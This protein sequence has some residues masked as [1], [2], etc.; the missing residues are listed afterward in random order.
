MR[1]I[2][3][4]GNNSGRNAGDNAILGNLLDDFTLSRQDIH[5]KI[6]S[7]NPGFIN[8]YF[9]HHSVEPMGM[10]PWNLALKNLGLPLY[11][12]MTRTEMVLITD[13]ILFDR[14]FNNPFVNYLKSIALF[15]DSC[16]KRKIPIV[17]YNAS[18]GPI[19]HAVGREALQ[20][21]MDASKLVIARDNNTKDL[22]QN[23]NLS[24]PEIIVHADCAL[25]TSIPSADHMDRI[26]KKEDLFKGANGTIGFN[27]NAYVDNWSKPGL[28]NRKDFVQII[29]GTIDN[30]ID[31]L[32]I[33]ILFTV[34][35]VMDLKITDECVQQVRNKDKVRVV[36]N[37]DY[38]YQELAGLLQ[39][40]DIHAGLRTHTL[41]FCAAVNTPMVNINA[42]P[43]SAGFMQTIGQGD[44]TLNFED[45][46]VDNLSAIMLKAW[47][48][49]GRTR[50]E[51]LPL[52]HTEKSKARDSVRLVTE[53]L[54]KL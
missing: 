5:F 15:S 51:M 41:I 22:I 54:D 1:T 38:T 25:N 36:N 35:Q 32:D 30:L 42:Y 53:L 20:K 31:K 8:K 12:A 7:L 16:S 3:V 13:N 4:L 17:F 2:T 6:P 28:L 24:H 40:V 47:D 33:D 44:W 27:V 48:R 37:N 11:L 45:L 39:K 49:R 34:S 19:D 10:M 46:S 18:I 21:V 50:K 29:A 43:K 26:I 52:V 9:G 14:K 23:L